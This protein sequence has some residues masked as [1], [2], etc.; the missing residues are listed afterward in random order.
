MHMVLWHLPL[1]LSGQLADLSREGRR[2]LTFDPKLA[3]PFR[4][5]FYLPRVLGWLECSTHHNVTL[6][7]TSGAGITL[8]RLNVAGV[9]YPSLPVALKVGEPPLVWNASTAGYAVRDV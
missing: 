3:C 1:A 9:P 8:D 6:R 7:V 4:L 2:S 5:P